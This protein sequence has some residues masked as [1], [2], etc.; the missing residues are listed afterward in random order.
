M[1]RYA[2]P[3]GT[4][5]EKFYSQMFI[6]KYP[7]LPCPRPPVKAEYSYQMKQVVADLKGEDYKPPE[8]SPEPKKKE[9]KMEK[10]LEAI[11]YAIAPMFGTYNVAGNDVTV[12]Q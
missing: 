6:E 7:P 12:K 11:E 3:Y 8:K 5:K 2:K 10:A 1:I 9:A 4:I